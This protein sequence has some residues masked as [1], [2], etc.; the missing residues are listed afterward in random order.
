VSAS[1]STG[2]RS[3]KA[4]AKVAMDIGQIPGVKVMGSKKKR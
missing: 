2:Q 3:G 4:G 1:G